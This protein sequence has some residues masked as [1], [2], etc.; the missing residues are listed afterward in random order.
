MGCHSRG[1]HSV[2]VTARV[3]F[4]FLACCSPV[5]CFSIFFLTNSNEF[6]SYQS[7]AIGLTNTEQNVMTTVLLT[8]RSRKLN[9]FPHIAWGLAVLQG[10][11]RE[12]WLFWGGGRDSCHAPLHE[13]DTQCAVSWLGLTA[14]CTPSSH[15]GPLQVRVGQSA[16]LSGVGGVQQQRGAFCGLCRGR[17]GHSRE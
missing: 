11:G 10:F 15:R 16:H 9:F 14:C 8:R 1:Q 5:V 17:E 13:Q 12:T 6:V 2:A 4:S 7:F 3:S